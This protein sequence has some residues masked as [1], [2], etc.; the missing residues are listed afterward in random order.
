MKLCEPIY[1]TRIDSKFNC[2]GFSDQPCSEIKLGGVAHLPE[3]FNFLTEFIAC[4]LLHAMQ[5]KQFEYH[6]SENN[7]NRLRLIIELLLKCEKG[8]LENEAANH[9]M[10]TRDHRLSDA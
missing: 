4:D 5:S 7:F 1:G 9:K 3:Y 2:R 10:A 6:H 8:C